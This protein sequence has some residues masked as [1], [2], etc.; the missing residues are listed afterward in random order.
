MDIPPD[1]YSLP[2]PVE[3]RN[4][5]TF[6]PTYA[7]KHNA[8]RPN[9]AT[10]LQNIEAIARVDGAMNEEAKMSDAAQRVV[11]EELIKLFLR[12]SLL[13]FIA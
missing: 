13:D 6:D 3:Y 11:S 1:Y 4:F 5:E 10:A 8:R 7:G 9:A 2:L 12:W